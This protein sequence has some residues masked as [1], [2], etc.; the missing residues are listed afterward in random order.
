MKPII[1]V[2]TCTH[3]PRLDYLDKVLGALSCQSLPMEQ[4]EFLLIDNASSKL[5]SAEIHLRWHPLARHIREDQLGLT[6]ARLRGIYEAEAELLVF[7]DDDNVL[8]PN[9][10]ESAFQISKIWPSLGVWGGQIKA[11]FEDI[12]PDWSKPY[13][14]LLGIRRFEKN[15]WS[16]LLHQ[17][18][19]TPYGAGMVVRK[20]VARAYTDLVRHDP[21]RLNLGR[22][23]D[24]LISCEDTDLAFTACDIGLGTGMFT[25]LEL[26]H[27]IPVTRLQEE[28]LLKLCE[29]ISYSSTMLE[30]FR[31]KFPPSVSRSEKIFET[32]QLWRMNPRKRR[33]KMA[34]KRGQLLALNKIK[35]S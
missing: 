23:G 14:Y 4:W 29:A 32:F 10:L 30:S 33:F 13:W 15:S 19:T 34:M 8:E 6:Y 9:Y 12:A 18:V 25:S 27:L 5:L 26:T 35:Q 17:Q 21:R 16:N 3:N 1:S 24:S 31:D 11:S 22:K 20:A 28:Y 2:I 7:V